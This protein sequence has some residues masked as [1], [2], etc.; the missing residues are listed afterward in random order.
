MKKFTNHT[1]GTRGI[2]TETG[3]VWIDPG[4]TVEVDP[5]AIVGEIPDLGEKSDGPADGPDAGNF[6]ALTAQVA[7]LTKQVEALTGERDAL[8]TEKAALEKG[9]AE[10]TK[11]V[12]ALKKPAK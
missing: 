12:E 10:L 9:N 5:K 4:Q 8:A 1:Q 3:M 2:R 7:E 11:Q 6:D